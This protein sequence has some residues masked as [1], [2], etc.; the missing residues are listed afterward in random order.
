VY[1]IHYSR[2]TVFIYNVCLLSC[3][4]SIGEVRSAMVQAVCYFCVTCCSPEF[5]VKISKFE[6]E[7]KQMYFKNTFFLTQIMN[8]YVDTRKGCCQNLSYLIRTMSIY[9]SNNGNGTH[10]Q[11]RRKTVVGISPYYIIIHSKLFIG[12]TS[13]TIATDIT[14]DLAAYMWLWLCST[15]SPHCCVIRCDWFPSLTTSRG[16]V[17]SPKFSRL[18]YAIKSSWAMTTV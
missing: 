15:S 14:G 13:C 9:I 11:V 18:V 5:Y 16:G 6:C 8:Q 1:C 10:D 2:F 3:W 4:S 7:C 17:R 12:Q